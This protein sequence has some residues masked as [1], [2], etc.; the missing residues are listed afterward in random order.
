MKKDLAGFGGGRSRPLLSLG[1]T[2]RAAMWRLRASVEMG[3]GTK[4]EPV[5]FLDPVGKVPAQK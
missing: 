5:V 1:G 3:A 4:P 2:S